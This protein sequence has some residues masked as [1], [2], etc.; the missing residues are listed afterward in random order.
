[1]FNGASNGISFPPNDDENDNVVVYDNRLVKLVNYDK[2]ETTYIG[3][4]DLKLEKHKSSSFAGD[5]S[6]IFNFDIFEQSLGC[7][8]CDDLSA[9]VQISVDGTPYAKSENEMSDY[10][11]SVQPNVGYT[12]QQ[13]KDATYILKLSEDIQQAA[14]NPF[15]DLASLS[16]VTIP[17]YDL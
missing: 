2:M 3:D 14:N 1:M 5:L 10:F 9:S 8:N 13:K 16:G 17:L 4:D 6:Y 11:I 12:Y 15:P 7:G